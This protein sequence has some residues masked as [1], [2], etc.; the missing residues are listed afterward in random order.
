M[1]LRRTL[2]LH[3]RYKVDGRGLLVFINNQ[4]FGEKSEEETRATATYRFGSEQD[5]LRIYKAFSPFDIDMEEENFKTN[6]TAQEMRDFVENVKEKV[7]DGSYG[8]LIFLISSHGGPNVVMGRDEEEIMIDEEVVQPF[9]NFHLPGLAGK[10]KIFIINACRG[11]NSTRWD[12]KGIGAAKEDKKTKQAN[13][14]TDKLIS[15][16]ARVPRKMV[17]SVGD[18]CV[19]Y[20]TAPDVVSPRDQETGSFFLNAL[21]NC[22]EKHAKDGDC[23]E[24]SKM[25]RDVQKICMKKNKLCVGFEN[26]LPL[27]FYLPYNCFYKEKGKCKQN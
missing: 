14:A 20:S 19:V 11:S 13:I 9:H 5:N 6:L 4:F 24:F 2:T 3:G 8:F 27:D 18:Y 23:Q 25:I 26:Y 15:I 12:V 17:S 16:S 1:A 7:S 10:P 21:R 22:I